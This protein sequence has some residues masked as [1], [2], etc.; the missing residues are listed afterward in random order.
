MKGARDSPI[1]G[2]VLYCGFWLVLHLAGA[3]RLE[4]FWANKCDLQVM[5]Y[6]LSTEER[7]KL[8]AAENS[9]ISNTA[10]LLNSAITVPPIDMP[11]KYSSVQTAAKLGW[12]GAALAW[13]GMYDNRLKNG[14]YCTRAV[15]GV[16]VV[17]DE[18]RFLDYPPGSDEG[19]VALRA[20]FYG[21]FHMLRYFSVA[22][23]PHSFVTLF[24]DGR[25]PLHFLHILSQAPTLECRRNRLL[26]SQLQHVA[27]E[28][29]HW[30]PRINADLLR[31]KASE[32]QD[33]E[34][35]RFIDCCAKH[36]CDSSAECTDYKSID[37]TYP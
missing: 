31:Y 19:F 35:A 25:V 15:A 37:R 3:G 23:I 5:W 17:R 26:C 12:P 20:L 7:V 28:L 14:I 24:P 36:S 21:H 8:L 27:S 18:M 2:G 6:R 22:Q 11:L 10:L 16:A 34:L 33:V 9:V 29:L 1:C 30:L 32:I 4:L 13:L